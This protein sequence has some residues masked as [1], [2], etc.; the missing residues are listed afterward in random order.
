[1]FGDILWDRITEKHVKM[2]QR[3]T[4]VLARRAR[5]ALSG[6]KGMRFVERSKFAFCKA[7]HQMVYRREETPSLDNQHYLDHGWIRAK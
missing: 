1:M 6:S 7:M 3:K 2:L 5:R 4:A